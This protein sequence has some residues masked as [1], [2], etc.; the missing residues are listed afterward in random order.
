V[1]GKDGATPTPLQVKYYGPDEQSDE[2]GENDQK[3]G[4]HNL[5]PEVFSAYGPDENNHASDEPPE[6]RHVT[7]QWSSEPADQTW[8]KS[9]VGSRC[10]QAPTSTTYSLRSRE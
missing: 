1:T 8:T 5:L 10:A 3:D 2:R 6:L 7:H 9:P 4:H